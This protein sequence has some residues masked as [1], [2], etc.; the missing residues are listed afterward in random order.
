MWPQAVGESAIAAPR[1]RRLIDAQP[2]VRDHPSAAVDDRL[3]DQRAQ[4]RKKHVKI[5]F[6]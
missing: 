2:R 4:L 1:T 5:T 6:G 3:D